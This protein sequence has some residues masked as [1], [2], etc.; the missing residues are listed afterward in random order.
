MYN[1]GSVH[2][3]AVE[4]F[5]WVLEYYGVYATVLHLKF[6]GPQTTFAIFLIFVRQIYFVPLIKK[7]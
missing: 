7:Y 4:L 3:I 5:L 6:V 2:F 1:P